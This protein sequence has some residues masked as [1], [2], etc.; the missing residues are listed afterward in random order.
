VNASEVSGA[1]AG[2][3]VMDCRNAECGMFKF[4]ATPLFLALAA[5]NYNEGIYLCAVP[6]PLSV[7]GTMWVMYLVM[8]IVHADSWLSLLRKVMA[9]KAGGRP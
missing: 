6:G 5:I 2:R 4:I 7:L 8:A 1:A 3:A 9:G